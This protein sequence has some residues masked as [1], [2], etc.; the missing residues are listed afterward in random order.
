MSGVKFLVDVDPTGAGIGLALAPTNIDLSSSTLTLNWWATGRRPTSATGSIQPEGGDAAS[1]LEVPQA[2]CGQSSDSFNIWVD[3]NPT[4]A[5]NASNVILRDD[6]S[7]IQGSSFTSQETFD[8]SHNFTW[9]SKRQFL[10]QR[11]QHSVSAW[12]PFDRYAVDA[13]EHVRTSNSDEALHITFSIRRCEGVK[14]FAI[15]LFLT[16]YVLAAAMVWVAVCA[17]YGPSLPE[18]ALFLPL[19][20]IL[21]LPQLRGAMP[22][23]PDFGIFMDLFGYYVNISAIC[24]AALFMF[25]KIVSGRRPSSIIGV[26]EHPPSEALPLYRKGALPIAVERSLSITGTV[27]HFDKGPVPIHGTHQHVEDVVA[28]FSENTEPRDVCVR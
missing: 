23:V 3:N 2:T 14:L 6:Q 12:Y 4:Y 27:E 24:F 25:F 1:I 22:G 10:A 7:A 15:T 28:M 16:N 17:H 8:T 19:T 9:I 20:N 18:S 21:L 13:I 26:T 11:R 5:W